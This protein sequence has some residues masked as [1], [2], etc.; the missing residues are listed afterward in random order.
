MTQPRTCIIC[1]KPARSG[2][3]LFPAALGGRRTHNG[4]YCKKHNEGFSSFVE[5]ITDQMAFF[6]GYIEV[7]HDRHKAF[8]P[9]TISSA[10]GSRY[11][12]DGPRLVPQNI[13]TLN[14][15]KISDG[16]EAVAVAVPESMMAKLKEMEASGV[17]EILAKGQPVSM[18]Q[19]KIIPFNFKFGGTKLLASISYLAMTY[20]AKYYPDLAREK[21]ANLETLKTSLLEM[22][23]TKED[24]VVVPNHVYVWWETSEVLEAL[25]A[26]PFCFTH[27]IVL[28]TSQENKR[29]VAFLCLFGF[30]CFGIDFG[31][32]NSMSDHTVVVH[33]DPKA[34]HPPNDM[35]EYLMPGIAQSIAPPELN[36]TDNLRKVVSEGITEKQL[37]SFMASAQDWQLESAALVLLGRVKGIPTGKQLTDSQKEVEELLADNSQ[38]VFNLMCAF[39][40]HFQEEFLQKMPSTVA[41]KIANMIQAQIEIDESRPNGLSQVAES[42]LFL[43]KAVLINKILQMRDKGQLTIDNAKMLLGGGE[44]MATVGRAMLLPIIGESLFDQ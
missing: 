32:F 24:E 40:K 41:D 27:T 21:T 3:H 11:V 38:R 19:D 23:E 6:N 33:L 36:P 9:P 7:R 42:S 34:P 31:E 14:R 39:A 35:I 43:A 12:I 26:S 4:I 37:S 15:S 44:G 13:R 18:L 8:K 30:I 5:L 29:A 16:P 1:G 10:D 25:P 28:S 17:I 22:A 2:E 20:F